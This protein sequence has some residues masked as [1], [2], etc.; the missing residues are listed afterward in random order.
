MEKVKET[1]NICLSEWF[2]DGN[3]R[4][5]RLLTSWQGYSVEFVQD[6][7]VVERRIMW[8]HSRYYAED[9]CENWVEGIIK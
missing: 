7:K 4:S 8:E 6:D 1:G 9:A 3:G 2:G 5:A